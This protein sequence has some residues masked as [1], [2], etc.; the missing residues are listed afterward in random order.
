MSS[1]EIFHLL[2]QRVQI[3][4]GREGLR[5]GMDA[6]LLGATPVSASRVLELGCGVAPA[7]LCYGYR[8]PEARLYGVEIRSEDAVLARQNAFMNRARMEVVSGDFSDTAFMPTQ[9]IHSDDFD[10]VLLNPPF[11]RRDQYTAPERA[12]RQSS[13]V[14]ETPLADWIHH[15]IRYTR[16][17]GWIAL[18]HLPERLPEILAGFGN[19]VGNIHILP[20][21]SRLGQQ[22]KRIMVFGQKSRAPGCRIAPALVMHDAEG[23]SLA[24][25]RIL[26]DAESLEIIL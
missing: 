14:E 3:R 11:Y 16:Q 13:H 10:L 7:L 12:A 4:Q 22:A 19:R 18:I 17:F 23:Y 9:G 20:V 1:S 6:V 15:S 26:E 8:E 21:Y 25:K 2:R 24:A 5:A